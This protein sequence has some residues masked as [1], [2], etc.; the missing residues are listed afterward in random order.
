MAKLMKLG[1]LLGTIGLMATVAGCAAESTNDGDVP[2]VTQAAEDSQF[3]RSLVGVWEVTVIEHHA[4]G[5]VTRTGT[6]TFEA[7]GGG[8]MVTSIGLHG[9]ATWTQKGSSIQF[10]YEHNLPPGG[11]AV[12]HQ[13]GT[14]TSYRCFTSTGVITQYNPDGSLIEHYAADFTST[15]KK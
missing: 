1:A 9:P 4:A 11:K 15:R 8:S 2:A 14:L 6:F 13:D 10:D 12:G 5:D 3:G 7:G